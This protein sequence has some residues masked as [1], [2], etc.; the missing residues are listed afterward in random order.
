MTETTKLVKQETTMAELET[1]TVKTKVE[2]TMLELGAMA[3]QKAMGSQ[4]TRAEQG[5]GV[6]KGW[7]SD[8][9]LQAVITA[10][11]LAQGCEEGHYLPTRSRTALPIS[12][13]T[14][15]QPAIGTDK[16]MAAAVK[17]AAPTLD[18]D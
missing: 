9:H 3:E 10:L 12:T 5:Q 8:N 4:G 16:H 11:F 18:Q 17:G 1:T 13:L 7:L 6:H 15:L 14:D 2:T